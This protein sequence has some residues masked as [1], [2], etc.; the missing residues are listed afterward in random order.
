MSLTTTQ[1][2]IVWAYSAA[3]AVLGGVGTALTAAVSGQAIGA[4]DFTPRQLGAIAIGGAITALAAYLKN[5]PLPAL[6]GD[7]K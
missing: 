4:I 5:S 2:L 7:D 6:F 1:K 3:A